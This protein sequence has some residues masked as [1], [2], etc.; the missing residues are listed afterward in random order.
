MPE[1]L[2]APDRGTGRGRPCRRPCEQAAL[3][4]SLEGSIVTMPSIGDLAVS[5]THQAGGLGLLAGHGRRA[6]RGPCLRERIEPGNNSPLFRGLRYQ[7]LVGAAWYRTIL[8]LGPG[9]VRLGMHRLG[10]PA[11]WIPIPGHGRWLSMPDRR[12]GAN[13]MPCLVERP[14]CQLKPGGTDRCSWRFFHRRSAS[15]VGA[16][17]GCR[18]GPALSFGVGVACRMAR[19]IATGPRTR[20]RDEGPPLQAG[21]KASRNTGGRCLLA[22]QHRSA[23]KAH[24]GGPGRAGPHP[25]QNVLP[26][27]GWRRERVAM[28]EHAW[29]QNRSGLGLEGDRR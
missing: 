3:N 25:S 6:R 23:G 14:S 16:R 4:W 24:P 20:G 26:P 28:F 9:G 19:P 13:S 17:S 11:H 2:D 1:G 22:W 5:P 21:M 29:V 27:P 8:Q 10:A 15:C 12:A 18:G 7:E